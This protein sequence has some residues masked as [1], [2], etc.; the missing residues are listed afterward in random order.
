[1]ETIIRHVDGKVIAVPTP[2][3]PLSRNARICY[4]CSA[5]VS[6]IDSHIVT[7]WVGTGTRIER[8]TKHEWSI[9]K[10][11]MVAYEVEKRR[12]FTKRDKV[13]VCASCLTVHDEVHQL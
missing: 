12:K 10:K 2:P 9:E 4:R 1:M 11:E 13:R 6:F 7:E 3:K 5:P 8:E